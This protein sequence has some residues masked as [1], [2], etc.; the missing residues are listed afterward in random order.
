MIYKS[1]PSHSKMETFCPIDQKH[2]KQQKKN[3]NYTNNSC[4]PS[5]V[6]AV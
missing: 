1:F 2:K 3:S 5:T 4:H 6:V